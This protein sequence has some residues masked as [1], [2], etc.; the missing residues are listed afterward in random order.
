[1]P[2]WGSRF[3]KSTDELV[4]RL[5]ASLPFDKRLYADDITASIVWSSGLEKAGVLT[6]Q[7]AQ[8]IKDGLETI[9]AEF[10]ASKFNFH[11]NDEDIHT[12]VERRL[13]EIVGP[14]GVKLHTGRNRNDQV[15]T[16]FRLWVMRACNRLRNHIGTLQK[17][18]LES[19]E[20]NMNTVM[21][22]YTH[23][24]PAQPIT[25]GHWALSHFW[26]LDRDQQRITQTHA[27]AAI[28]PLGSGAL[29]GSA[30]DINRNDL[31][32]SLGFNAVSQNSL[33]AVSD[34]DF[35][36]D[37][38]FS[39]AMIGIHLSRLSE[40]LILFTSAEFEFVELDDAYAT[41]SS[42]LPQKKNPD[43]LELTRG[44]SGRLIGNLTGLLATLKGLPSAY[45]KDLQE[46][47]EPLFDADDTVELALQVM[48]GVVSTMQLRPE[49]MAARIVPTLFSTDLA[50]YL[51]E[52]N[53]P[54][55][56]AHEIVGKVVRHAEERGMSID[57]LSLT[58]LQTFSTYFTKNVIEVF[59]VKTALMRR[60]LE[61]GTAPNALLQ[62]L[63]LA[64]SSISQ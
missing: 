50:D 7:E 26:P 52:R 4:Q 3:D 38:L 21:P 56:E 36:A 27:R 24:Q 6:R 45:D 32:D 53:V 63:R 19:A 37:F 29:A 54:F 47:K 12:A 62:Q 51:V 28:L 34:R 2:M 64:R 57:E 16:D 44:K 40:Q 55:R 42:L 39:A 5:N 25:W 33:D 15:A 17:A 43:T 18:L 1:M 49:K 13:V 30:F 61:G 11:V 60:T 14:V 9:R 46:D 41:G 59:D 22:G 31:A 8:S 10:D 48:S 35:A 58:E 23:L 20:T